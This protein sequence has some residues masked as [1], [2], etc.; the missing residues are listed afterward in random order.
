[1]KRSRSLEIS[2]WKS[3]KRISWSGSKS[4]SWSRGVISCIGVGGSWDGCCGSI[5]W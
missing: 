1:M 3:V 5:K 4:V 2:C